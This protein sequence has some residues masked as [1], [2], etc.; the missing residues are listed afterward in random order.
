MGRQHAVGVE[1][2]SLALQRACRCAVTVLVEAT[3]LAIAASALAV[4]QAHLLTTYRVLAEHAL[5]GHTVKLV[6]ASVLAVL[7]VLLR[8]W[9]M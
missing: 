7:R 8:P 5:V 6:Q 3:A 9:A 4:L 2:A 1:L